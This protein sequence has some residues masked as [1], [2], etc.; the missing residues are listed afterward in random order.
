M[1]VDMVRFWCVCCEGHLWD[2]CDRARYPQAVQ[3]AKTLHSTQVQTM[4]PK[5]KGCTPTPSAPAQK[6]TIQQFHHGIPTQ[7][8]TNPNATPAARRN[9]K[10]SIRDGYPHHRVS[11]PTAPPQPSTIMGSMYSPPTAH[12]Q[13]AYLPPKHVSMQSLNLGALVKPSVGRTITSHLARLAPRAC[14]SALNVMHPYPS[15]YVCKSLSAS[16]HRASTDR[17]LSHAGVAGDT[18][19]HTRPIYVCMSRA[20]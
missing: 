19:I 1:Q 14:I 3:H 7:N 17:P 2:T 20:T 18:Y 16:H 12:S 4:N 10:G 13:S 11:A 8:L 9:Q 5:P 15:P 6:A